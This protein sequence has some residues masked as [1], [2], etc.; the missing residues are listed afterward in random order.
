MAEEEEV[1]PLCCELMEES[2][3]NFEPCPCGY[4]VRSYDGMHF[5]ATQPEMSA[6]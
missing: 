4:Q 3:H 1:C 2:D 6:F 5:G